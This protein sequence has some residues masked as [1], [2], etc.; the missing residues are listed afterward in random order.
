[1]AP[2]FLDKKFRD[3]Y[4]RAEITRRMLCNIKSEL[5]RRFKV[6]DYL[7]TFGG[8]PNLDTDIEDCLTIFVESKSIITGMFLRDTGQRNRSGAYTVWSKSHRKGLKA[9]EKWV[10]RLDDQMKLFYDPFAPI[11]ANTLNAFFL[12]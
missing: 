4:F 7:C 10:T 9:A 8:R 5:N 11:R 3:R 1:M 6:K 2:D 12:K